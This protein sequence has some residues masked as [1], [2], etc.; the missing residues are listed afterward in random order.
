MN[1]PRET[2]NR[3]NSDGAIDSKRQH[4][5]I[6]FYGKSKFTSENLVESLHERIDEVRGTC[7]ALEARVKTLEK[8]LSHTDLFNI[9]GLTESVHCTCKEPTIRMPKSE[10]KGDHDGQGNNVNEP[11]YDI[12][13]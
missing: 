1:D 3:A 11:D 2:A 13:D 7:Q 6:L 8:G 12:C 10:K 4:P 9:L 5:L